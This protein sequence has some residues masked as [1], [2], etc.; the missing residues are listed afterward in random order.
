MQ[1]G[2]LVRFVRADAAERSV[3]CTAVLSMNAV[4]LALPFVS[5][6]RI[7]A[8]SNRLS[9]RWQAR[10]AGTPDVERAARRIIQAKR[11][12]PLSTCLSESIGAH[13]VMSRLGHES[14]LRIGV[15]KSGEKF[16]AHAWLECEGNVIIGNASPEGKQYVRMPSL[17]RFVA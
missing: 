16:E 11:F 17:P 14:E 2:R 6:Q 7:I 1:P 4:R 13:F 12:C 15:A 8:L 5:V 10:A 9:R 3:F